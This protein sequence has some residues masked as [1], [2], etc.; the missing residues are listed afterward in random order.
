MNSLSNQHRVQYDCQYDL[1]PR[2]T[3]FVNTIRPH[4]VSPSANLYEENSAISPPP[5]TSYLGSIVSISCPIHR[6]A[7]WVNKMFFLAV[8]STERNQ[9]GYLFPSIFFISR[10]MIPP[11]LFLYVSRSEKSIGEGLGAENCRE[12]G[13]L[14]LGRV[15]GGRTAREY[16]SVMTKW[17]CET[18]YIG[19]LIQFW[20]EIFVCL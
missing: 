17:I 19:L 4:D 12:I 6:K 3:V 20:R 7:L 9:L 8:R 14:D 15:L 5:T 18:R 11:N 2:E 1:G 10:G 16:L 13:E